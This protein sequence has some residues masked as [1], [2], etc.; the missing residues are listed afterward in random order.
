MAEIAG[1]SGAC[2]TTEDPFISIIW[3]FINMKEITSVPADATAYRMRVAR[4]SIPI[5]IRWQGDSAEG[6]S[7]AKDRLKRV[8][9]VVEQDLKHI[10]PNGPGEDDTGY[11]NYG[12]S[13]S[14]SAKVTTGLMPT[15]AT[16]ARDPLS[17]ESAAGLF[18]RNYPR[19]QQLKR[20]Y[21]PCML[22]SHSACPVS[23]RSTADLG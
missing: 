22:V 7:D 6:I 21:G 4:P 14:L 23:W 11:R 2:V 17:A 9:K 13:Y 8:K 3:E 19:L 10:F 20:K 16:D 18:G 1:A 5:A 15:T 12:M